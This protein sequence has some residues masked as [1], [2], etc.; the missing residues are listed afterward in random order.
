VRISRALA[1]AALALID[2][3]GALAM[4]AA[5]KAAAPGY[6]W[7]FP[8]DHWP[9]REYRTEWWYL[10]GHLETRADPPRR[11][12]YQLTFFRI[13]VASAGPEAAASPAGESAW[14]APGLIMG[15]AAL[16]DIDG[17][18]HLFSELLYREIDL[19]GGFAAFPDPRLAWSRA[20]AGTDAAWTLTFNGDAFDLSMR[21]D[22]QGFGL[23]LTTRPLK[24]LVLQGPGGH[25]RKGPDP[26]SASLY[27]SFTR[28]GTEGTVRLDGAELEVTGT[29][30]MDKEFGSNQLGDQQAG[31][32]WFSLQLADGRDLMLY[33]MRRRD[34]GT[35]LRNGTIV[36]P[37]GEARYLQAEDWTLRA[38]EQ[39]TSPGTGATYPAGW[40]VEIPAERLR[41]RIDPVMAD[42]ENRTGRTGAP[43]YYEGA[44]VVTGEPGPGGR[45]YVELAGYGEDNSPPI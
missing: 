25:S 23:E 33:V 27:Y 38:T 29:S 10:T 12:G 19:L 8:R 43:Y 2:C 5:W 32:D 6:D 11:F 40:I 36:S 17:G 4:A 7:S 22:A 28:L 18:R 41:L 44:V 16:T 45:G 3:A 30:W 35:D 24:P 21:D 15:H 26:G 34:G 1:P 39:W 37:A 13:G 14:K 42:Q 20:P 9:H 31:W